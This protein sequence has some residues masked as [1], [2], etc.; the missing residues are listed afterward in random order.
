MLNRWNFLKTG[1]YEGIKHEK[2]DEYEYEYDYDYDYDYDPR[3]PVMSLMDVS[4]QAALRDQSPLDARPDILVYATAPLERPITVI[5]P[6]MLKL[7]GGVLS[8]G[9]GLHG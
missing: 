3:D 4:A 5:G 7:C 1:F 2:P 9:H 6:V 8:P